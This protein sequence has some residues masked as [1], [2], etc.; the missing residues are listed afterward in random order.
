MG[1][2]GFIEEGWPHSSEPVVRTLLLPSF[3]PEVCLTCSGEGPTLS[4]VAPRDQLW[5]TEASSLEVDCEDISITREELDRVIAILSQTIKAH[6]QANLDREANVYYFAVADGM[7]TES[8]LVLNQQVD[9]L[10][11]H[12][13]LPEVE[14][15]VI[16]LLALAWNR[17]RHPAIRNALAHAASHMGIEYPL[18]RSDIPTPTRVMVLGVDEDRL[19]YLDRLRAKLARSKAN[20]HPSSD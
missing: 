9:Q 13:S 1:L 17:S 15:Y 3:L 16:H 8:C 7:G 2:P 6:H 12:A 4:I 20:S 18:D 14:T 19:S 5:G 10:N 11:I